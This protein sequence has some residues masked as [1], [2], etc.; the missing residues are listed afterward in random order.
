M[1]LLGGWR[2]QVETSLTSSVLRWW[3]CLWELSGACG[4]ASWVTKGQEH[5]G[6]LPHPRPRC[7]WTG[8]QMFTLALPGFPRYVPVALRLTVMRTERWPTGMGHPV[9]KGLYLSHKLLVRHWVVCPQGAPRGTQ[10]PTKLPE[11]LPARLATGWGTVLATGPS[12]RTGGGFF[13]GLSG[14]LPGMWKTKAGRESS[15]SLDL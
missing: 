8:G 11:T 13:R 3:G 5:S 9:G 7:L 15:I 12:P 4:W 14:R 1:V 6:V 10:K 2:G